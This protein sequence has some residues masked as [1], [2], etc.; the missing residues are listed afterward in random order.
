MLYENPAKSLKDYHKVIVDPVL[1]HYAPDTEG[2]SVDPDD[3][4]ELADYFHASVVKGLTESKRYQVVNAPGAGVA[5]LRI[6]ITAS[7]NP[8]L[9]SISSRA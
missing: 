4:K 8:S 6:A 5:G 9:Y 1:A 3:L 2:A 7:K